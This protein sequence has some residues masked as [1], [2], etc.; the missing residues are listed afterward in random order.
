MQRT[1]SKTLSIWDKKVFRCSLLY[2]IVFCFI[3]Y[4]FS[5]CLLA[6]SGR[7]QFISDEIVSQLV[8]SEGREGWWLSRIIT[9]V[10]RLVVEQHTGTEHT[11]AKLRGA[12]GKI[13]HF[14]LTIW[15]WNWQK[16]IY[17][18]WHKLISTIALINLQI[19]NADIKRYVAFNRHIKRHYFRHY[20]LKSDKTIESPPSF[21]FLNWNLPKLIK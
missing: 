6:G 17:F 8:I 18:V 5:L 11:F 7:G 10:V 16:Y 20:E 21:L 19:L 2:F 14:L 9:A 4:L 3:L 15:F 1:Q 13:W 12:R